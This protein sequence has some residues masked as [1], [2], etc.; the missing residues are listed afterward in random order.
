MRNPCKR[1]SMS[2][3]S[4]REA[5]LSAKS[6]SG[7]DRQE[8]ARLRNLPSDKHSYSASG[9]AEFVPCNSSAGI[10]HCTISW[11]GRPSGDFCMGV[12]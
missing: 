2:G 6:T 4:S 10:G 1:K 9:I 11:N 5:S 3:T 8:E 7:E 12:V